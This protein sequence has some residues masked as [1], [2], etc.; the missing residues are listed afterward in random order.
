LIKKKIPQT[1]KN[2]ERGDSVGAP[3]L[4]GVED[5]GVDKRSNKSYQCKSYIN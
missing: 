4:A 5:A 1:V 2:R 3:E